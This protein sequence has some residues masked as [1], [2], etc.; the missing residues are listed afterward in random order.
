VYAKSNL[1]IAGRFE[2]TNAANPSDLILSTT[3][4]LGRAMEGFITNPINN[5]STIRGET[6]GTGNGVVGVGT[7]DNTFNAGVYGFHSGRQGN[8]VIAMEPNH[9]PMV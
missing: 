8:G 9:S 7:N 4:G 1:G 3:N 6:N 5:V 2:N